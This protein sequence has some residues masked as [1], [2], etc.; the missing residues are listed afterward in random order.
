MKYKSDGTNMY[1]SRE[2]RKYGIWSRN[3]AVFHRVF[4]L[5][6]FGIFRN[7]T[8]FNAN[9]DLNSE[10]WKHKIPAEFRGHSMQG[11]L[12]TLNDKQDLLIF[13]YANLKIK[14]IT[15]QCRKR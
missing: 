3:T 5:L 9:T 2:V 1:N 10:V 8:E 6:Y 12:L 13:C 4:K 11:M 14:Q 7:S 15:P